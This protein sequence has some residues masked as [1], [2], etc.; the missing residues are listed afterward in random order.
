M[1]QF[2]ARKVDVRKMSRLLKAL[3][4]ETRLRIVALLT[5]GELCV[6]HIEAGLGLTQSNASRQFAVLR[7]AE[8]VETR[9]DGNWVYYRLAPQADAECKRVLGAVVGEFE[10]REIL[11]EDVERLLKVKGP[12]ACK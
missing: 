10:K 12:T 6:C 5:H 7:A 11:R 4:D 3:S 2:A 8:V 1:T 9:R